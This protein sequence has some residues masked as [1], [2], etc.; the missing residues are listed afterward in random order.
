M[1]EGGSSG[2]VSL[3]AAAEAAGVGVR[4]LRELV[5][6][7]REMLAEDAPWIHEVWG[8]I[9]G[10]DS[11]QSEPLEDMLW[12]SVMEG[13][14]VEKEVRDKEGNVVKHEVTRKSNAELGLKLL[15]M[16][17]ERYKEKKG[18][19]VKVT[20]NMGR[21]ELRRRH[22]AKQR[23]EEISNLRED[24]AASV[25]EAVASSAAEPEP[26]FDSFEID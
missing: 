14:V 22:L 20:I 9:E 4:D 21:D 7:S 11:K 8:V 19:D 24:G 1:L 23:L 18:S 26:E 13:G 17:D 12:R 3:R 5:E 25:G 16:K 6:R 2:G 10:R 15:S